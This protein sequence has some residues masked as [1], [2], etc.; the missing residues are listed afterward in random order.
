[1]D[2]AVTFIDVFPGLTAESLRYQLA[3]PG[4]KGIVLKTYGA[5]NGPTARWFSDAIAEAV[6][7]G[8][9]ILNVTQCPNG[10][11]HDRRYYS[12]D[13][14]ANAG[15]ISG[16]DITSEAAITKMMFLFGQKLT[17][18]QVKRELLTSMCGEMTV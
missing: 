8:I 4:V 14:L 10:G 3:M 1:M 9:I 16:H 6:E 13:R 2:T 18:Q 11:V 15:V 12:G 7:R 5:G 17:P